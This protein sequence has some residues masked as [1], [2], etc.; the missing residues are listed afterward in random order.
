MATTIG[1]FTGDVITLLSIGGKSGAREILKLVHDESVGAF[2]R[3]GIIASLTPSVQK[4][5]AF[6]QQILGRALME[7]VD[8]DAVA[9]WAL[10]DEEAN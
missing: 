2:L 1:G 8:W 10:T 9:E 5:P 7:H 6:A 3:D 4:L